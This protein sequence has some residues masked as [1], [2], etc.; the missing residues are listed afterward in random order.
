MALTFYEIQ[1]M[2]NDAKKLAGGLKFRLWAWNSLI[3]MG[4]ISD[5]ET[6]SLDGLVLSKG[7]M[8]INPNRSKGRA[9]NTIWHEIGH[10]VFGNKPHWWIELF[11]QRIS[12]LDYYGYSHKALGSNANHVGR[13]KYPVSTLKFFPSRKDLIVQMQKRVSKINAKGQ[14]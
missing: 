10:I 4:R 2:V 9:L 11:A 3:R 12:G 14:R 13:I 8:A 5:K 1:R 6:K 7:I